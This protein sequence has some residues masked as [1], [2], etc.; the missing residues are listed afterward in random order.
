[1]DNRFFLNVKIRVLSDDLPLLKMMEYEQES[2]GKKIIVKVADLNI[3]IFIWIEYLTAS[4]HFYTVIGSYV[5]LFFFTIFL[6]AA[7]IAAKNNVS[8]VWSAVDTEVCTKALQPTAIILSLSG[9]LQPP[10]GA[11]MTPSCPFIILYASCEN[12]V[13][14]PRFSS[15]VMCFQRA[16]TEKQH[17]LLQK[18]CP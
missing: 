2:Y 12:A 14:T 10:Q 8:L 7:S 17:L 9:K 13:F 4:K 11:F 16:L 1:M 15:L 18:N 5:C 3:W 6:I